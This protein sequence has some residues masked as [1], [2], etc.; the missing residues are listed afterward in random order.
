MY[1]WTSDEKWLAY[2]AKVAPEPT[3][4]KLEEMR[5]RWY[6]VYIDIKFDCTNTTRSNNT[7]EPQVRQ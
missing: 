1:D 5:R 2:V 6:K 7:I 3:A 4:A